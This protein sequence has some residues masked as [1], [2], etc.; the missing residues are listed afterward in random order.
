M[1]PERW[2]LLIDHLPESGPVQMARD[3]AHAR[4]ASASPPTLRI[5]RWS[6]PTV[7]IGRFQPWRVAASAPEFAG[8]PLVRRPSGGRAVVHGEDICCA[9]T[10]PRRHPLADLPVAES[11]RVVAR[12]LVRGLAG[13]GIDAR[14]VERR[15]RAR[16]R[17]ISCREAFS[18]FE[19]A[20]GP[21]KLV[22]SAQWRPEAG[23]LQH[24]SFFPSVAARGFGEVAGA[25][26][27]GLGEAMEIAFEAGGPTEEES[28]LAKDLAR[29]KYGAKS[30]N[31]E[32]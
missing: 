30:W 3:E 16:E 32:R 6:G 18:L 12:G 20:C 5:Y 29:D 9:I 8:L 10:L 11:C 31:E 14:A 1:P 27:R 26:T 17:F 24:G 4:L 13:L 23:F 19:I 22:G 15:N 28:V 2:R 7:P 25:I 21:E